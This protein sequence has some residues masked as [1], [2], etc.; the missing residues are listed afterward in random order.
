MIK[1]KIG[2]QIAGK[3]VEKK[4]LMKAG[5]ESESKRKAMIIIFN[6]IE[7]F[8]SDIINNY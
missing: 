3:G 2:R 7:T 1:E 8:T 4:K 5:T 6:L